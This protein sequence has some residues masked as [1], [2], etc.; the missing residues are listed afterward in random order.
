MAGNGQS[1]GCSTGVGS[2]RAGIPLPPRRARSHLGSGGAGQELEG[3]PGLGAS[4][5]H[6]CPTAAHGLDQALFCAA[7]AKAHSGSIESSFSGGGEVLAHCLIPYNLACYAA[8]LR[9]LWEAERWLKQAL[10]IGGA[11]YR[12]MALREQDLRPLWAKIAEL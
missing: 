7:P 8:Q 10:Q 12:S 9:C 2:C 1:R 4:H 6:H 5:C 3:V 11:E